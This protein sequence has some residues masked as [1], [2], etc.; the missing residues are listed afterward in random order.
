MHILEDL[1]NDSSFLRF[2][3]EGMSN[4]YQSGVFEF[5]RELARTQPVDSNSPNYIMLLA[6]QAEY[7]RGYNTALDD[8]LNFREKYLDVPDIKKTAPDYGAI[9]AAIKAGDLTEKEA[10]EFRSK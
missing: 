1:K 6:A 3:I 5:L 2:F 9:D 7:S 8:I 4:L 10:D